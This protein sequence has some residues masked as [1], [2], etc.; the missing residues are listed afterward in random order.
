[1]LYKMMPVLVALAMMLGSGY[2]EAQNGRYAP[3]ASLYGGPGVRATRTEL[4]DAARVNDALKRGD[5][6]GG[7][8]VYNSTSVTYSTVAAGCLFN[9]TY[10]SDSSGSGQS[11][12][13]TSVTGS[14]DCKNSGQVSG[15]LNATGQG[16][17]GA[18]GIAPQTYKK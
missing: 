14:S 12:G 6:I 17:A 1:M 13:N 4:L 8:T 18:G 11:G 10:Y 2:A 5:P 3:G 7:G 15:Q 9:S 16:N